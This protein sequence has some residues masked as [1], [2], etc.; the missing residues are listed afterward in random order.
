MHYDYMTPEDRLLF[1]GSKHK[2][3]D[4]IFKW[5]L[6]GGAVYFLGHFVYAVL[7]GAL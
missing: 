6:A 2:R 7:V 1:L 4:K 5:A 3:S